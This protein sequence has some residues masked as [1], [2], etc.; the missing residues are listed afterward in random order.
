MNFLIRTFFTENIVLIYKAQMD[1]LITI[2][3]GVNPIVPTG[4]ITCHRWEPEVLPFQYQFSQPHA[5]QAYKYHRQVMPFDDVHDGVGLF[6]QTQPQRADTEGGKHRDA[7]RP[8]MMGAGELAHHEEYPYRRQQCQHGDA[9]GAFHAVDRWRRRRA[10]GA[11]RKQHHQREQRERDGRCQCDTAH[12]VQIGKRQQGRAQAGGYYDAGKR[13]ELGNEPGF[14][15]FHHQVGAQA[16]DHQRT[17][18]IEHRGRDPFQAQQHRMVRGLDCSP[19]P[20]K[21]AYQFVYVSHCL[22]GFYFS[23]FWRN[24]L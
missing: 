7:A 1:D 12:L 15:Q 8:V 3:H 4:I 23:S 19:V 16:G 11:P 9:E 20:G 5:D 17:G 24:I 22:S 13:R 14:M 6:I 18:E 10:V 2:C 21:F